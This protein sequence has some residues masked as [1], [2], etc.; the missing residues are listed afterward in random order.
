MFNYYLHFFELGVL[1]AFLAIFWKE[2]RNK[3]IVE[4]I[5]LAFLYGAALETFNVHLSRSYFYSADFF[6]KIYDIP[7]A[8]GMGWA[9]I[10]YCAF[11]IGK[12]Y[13][14]KWWQEPFLMALLALSFDLAMD[15]VAI[16]LGFWTWRIPINEEW[17][18]VPYDN[19]FGWMA[20]VWTFALLM[21][22]SEK[23]YF[24][25][26]ISKAIK[27]LS[28]IISPILLSLQ[29]TIYASVSAILSGRFSSS[30]IFKF[31]QHRD[32]S[33]AYYFAVQNFKAYIFWITVALL[34]FSFLKILGSR[35]S[36]SKWKISFRALKSD[37]FSFWILAMAHIFFLA[38]IFTSGI[39]KELPILAFIALLMLLSHIALSSLR[40]SSK[41]EYD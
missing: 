26:K 29:I 15:A 11:K 16:R 27:Y 41:K 38:S 37:L 9:I 18:G 36:K 23:K 1:A 33:Y 10:Y 22:L 12:N 31:Y 30:E 39:Y 6:L 20:V 13:H 35:A 40:V 14:L 3:E 17:F 32:F 24:S 19:L 8:I 34:L 25:R 28:V 7:L 5:F 4:K 21:N 2:R